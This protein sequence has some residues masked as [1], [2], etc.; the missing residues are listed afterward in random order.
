MFPRGFLFCVLCVA[1][2]LYVSGV[3]AP[4][5]SLCLLRP[6]LVRKVLW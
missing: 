1:Y 3:L 2:E 5:S 6:G 4:S